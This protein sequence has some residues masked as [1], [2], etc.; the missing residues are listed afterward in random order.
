MNDKAGRYQNLRSLLFTTQAELQRFRELVVNSVMATDI[1][2]KELKELRNARWE[3]AF[4]T[5]TTTAT[6]ASNDSPRDQINRKATIVIEHLIQASD[7]SHTMQHWCVSVVSSE[8]CFVLVDQAASSI[9][10]LFSLFC[11]GRHIYRKWNER[12]FE[13]MYKAWKEGR[14]EKSPAE[15]WAKVGCRPPRG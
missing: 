2:D 8:R 12:L 4:R 6:G 3:K 11:H 14:S 5:T 1:C 9:Y 13:E 15:F 7:V 10:S